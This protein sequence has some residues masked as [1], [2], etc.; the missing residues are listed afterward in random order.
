MQPPITD[1][2]AAGLNLIAKI[3]IKHPE[4]VF[5]PPQRVHKARRCFGSIEFNVAV[6]WPHSRVRRDVLDVYPALGQ[7]ET[8]VMSEVAEIVSPRTVTPI[9]VGS[10]SAEL[11]FGGIM[12]ILALIAIAAYNLDLSWGFF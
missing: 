7:L 10:P 11:I 3:P 2:P 9:N 4:S 5:L 12:A 8:C 1:G 6:S